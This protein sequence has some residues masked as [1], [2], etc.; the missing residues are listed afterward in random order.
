HAHRL[1]EIGNLIY[2]T[3]KPIPSFEYQIKHADGARYN[4]DISISLIKDSTGQPTGY[5]GILRDV[6]ER[7]QAEKLIQGQ[8]KVLEMIATGAPLKEALETLVRLVEGLSKNTI[9][10]I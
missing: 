10:S 2:C 1:R 6:T 5:R 8:M 3:G 4:V 9:C 7:R